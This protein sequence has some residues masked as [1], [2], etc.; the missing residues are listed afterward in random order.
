MTQSKRT[1]APPAPCAFWLKVQ[2]VGGGDTDTR[3]RIAVRFA[4]FLSGTRIRAVVS[5]HLIGLHHP[6]G[7]VPFEVS[8]ILAWLSAQ[9]EVKALDFLAPVP[10]LLSKGVRHG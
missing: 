7:L 2:F 3:R 1:S 4:G 9:E 5:R 10:T 6:A 8:L